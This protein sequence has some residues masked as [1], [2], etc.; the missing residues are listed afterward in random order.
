MGTKWSFTLREDTQT[1]ER[2][3][4][5]SEVI[6]QQRQ[7]PSA[8]R[9]RVDVY[10]RAASTTR[11]NQRSYDVAEIASR[12]ARVLLNFNTSSEPNLL[13]LP[14]SIAGALACS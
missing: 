3:A 14:S 10:T 12:V 13:P 8:T 11:D 6:S 1:I 7:W 9:K 4:I 2:L 5:S